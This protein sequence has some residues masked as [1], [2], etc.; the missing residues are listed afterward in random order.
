MFQ[1]IK[2]TLVLVPKINQRAIALSVYERVGHKRRIVVN[3]SFF[4][5]FVLNNKYV[6]SINR[7]Y[8]TCVPVKNNTL[9]LEN[10][11][12]FQVN[13]N[14]NVINVAEGLAIH[15]RCI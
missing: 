11:A 8:C 15:T 3:N 7:H 13:K 4:L 14:R 2:C 5:L 10:N 6:F 9:F 1:G 12:L